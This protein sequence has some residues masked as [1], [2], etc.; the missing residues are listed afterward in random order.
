MNRSARRLALW[1]TRSRD[2]RPAG[3]FGTR[4]RPCV[5][6]RSQRLRRTQGCRCWAA[7]R[8]GGPPAHRPRRLV[9]LRSAAWL[10]PWLRR[11]LPLDACRYS[12]L[13]VLPPL[14]S[15]LMTACACGQTQS[16]EEGFFLV[17]AATPHRG[18]RLLEHFGPSHD[19]ALL[20]AVVGVAVLQELLAASAVVGASSPASSAQLVTKIFKLSAIWG[21]RVLRR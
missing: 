8:P 15:E 19:L 17:V 9:G 20:G 11:R 7:C 18:D 1:G 13:A 6:R 2:G 5:P 10:C 14:H 12:P 16:G 3:I 21:V 4:R